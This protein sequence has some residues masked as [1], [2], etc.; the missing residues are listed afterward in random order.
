MVP[1]VS[2][3]TD[4]PALVP[5]L[6]FGW[7]GRTVPERISLTSYFANN[8]FGNPVDNPKRL[9]FISD[10]MNENENNESKRFFAFNSVTGLFWDGNAFNAHSCVS[11]NP[12]ED[13]TIPH[14]AIPL[15]RA[16][17]LNV[18]FLEVR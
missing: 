17:W 4:R 12:S 9:G 6:I 16:T 18:Q 11:T 14:H 5:V 3:E 15:M 10:A 7:H 1:I 8:L 13:W 2:R